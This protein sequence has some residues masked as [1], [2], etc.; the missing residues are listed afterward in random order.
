[1]PVWMFVCL[2]WMLLT[3]YTCSRVHRG[4]VT[5]KVAIRIEHKTCWKLRTRR[6]SSLAK[7]FPDNSHR[8][9]AGCV[10][11]R[12]SVNIRWT[13][14]AATSW[15]LKISRGKMGESLHCRRTKIKDEKEISKRKT[16]I[17]AAL[18]CRASWN[19]VSSPQWGFNL[20]RSLAIRL[21]CLIECNDYLDD[22]TDGQKC[23]NINRQRRKQHF[24]NEYHCHPDDLLMK[25]EYFNINGTFI[26]DH[27]V[28]TANAPK[29]KQRD[30]M[31]NSENLENTVSFLGRRGGGGRGG[32]GCGD[33]CRERKFKLI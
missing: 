15:G 22:Q 11:P 26:S 4:I 18:M 17:R 24:H 2:F 13:W 23:I 10:C 25:Y 33:V 16:W 28:V 27:F 29:Q 30:I 7:L 8:G 14:C 5:I 21:C 19:R 20:F 9:D 31:K 12:P 1:M 6:L 32:V 3:S